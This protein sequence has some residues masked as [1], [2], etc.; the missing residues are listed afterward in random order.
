MSWAF[1]FGLL[2]IFLVGFMFQFALGFFLAV[3]FGE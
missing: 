3:T 1:F 2:L